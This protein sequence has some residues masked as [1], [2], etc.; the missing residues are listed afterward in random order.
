ME[1]AKEGL[2]MQ[3]NQVMLN[4]GA[5]MN[6]LKMVYVEIRRNKMKNMTQSNAIKKIRK[7]RNQRVK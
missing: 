5:C 6:Y 4:L 2:N 7:D 1:N 3:R